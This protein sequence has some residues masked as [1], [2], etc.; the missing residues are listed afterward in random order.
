MYTVDVLRKI[1]PTC[2]LLSLCLAF[3]LFLGVVTYNFR[4]QF[5]Q[6]RVALYIRLLCGY[7]FCVVIAM[8]Y[9]RLEAKLLQMLG[10]WRYPASGARQPVEDGTD[11]QFQ[12]QLKVTN[13]DFYQL[14]TKDL[15]RLALRAF[16]LWH[17]PIFAI[18]FAKRGVFVVIHP[19]TER[20]QRSV[21][22]SIR[23]HYYAH[24]LFTVVNDEHQICWR[25]VPVHPLSAKIYLEQITK[26]SISALRGLAE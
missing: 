5:V 7:N 23:I 13:N 1:S 6:R 20:P 11:G 15:Q 8:R 2:A 4:H 26:Q 17:I 22:K 19:T 16:T 9:K 18:F 14:S 24:E 21:N 12:I 3:S 10:A 25:A